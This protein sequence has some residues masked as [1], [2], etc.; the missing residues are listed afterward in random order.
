MSF[1]IAAN[2]ANRII[3]RA[4]QG[5]GGGGCFAMCTII[6]M[7]LVPKQKYTNLVAFISIVYAISLI[8][9][10]IV[11][12]AISKGTTWRWVFLLNV[13][14]A[15]P[16]V[17]IIYF[18]VPRGFPYHNKPKSFKQLT[19]KAT[20]KRVDF[21]GSALLLLATL[22][23][24]AAVEEAGLL[25]GWRSAFVI[26][27]LV[28]SGVLWIL[29]FLWERHITLDHD[30][31][32]AT[33]PVFPWRFTKNRV[34]L[35]MLLYAFEDSLR[36]GDTNASRN[37]SFLGGCW[38][39]TIFQLPLRYQIVHGTSP[40]GAGIRSMPFIAAAPISSAVSAAMSKKGVPP[41]YLVIG[42][43]LLEVIGFSL[44]ATM[45]PTTAITARQYGFEILAG[46]GCG[47]NISLL[48]LLVPFSVEPRDTCM[49]LSMWIN[50][51]R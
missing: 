41:L 28:L 29:F 33:E 8:I 48:V 30:I 26:T 17:L 34:W 32:G 5:L 14:L 25:L 23:L 31:P 45:T 6:C 21:L 49:F 38:F 18:C 24:V 46:F 36:L 3:F 47:T 16:A 13:P 2:G 11:G 4:F 9:G 51:L 43:S 7:D 39:C 15:L 12:G 50:E 44:L 22:S 1:K 19:S 40:L 42:T 35:G 10:P 20:M 37:A 27:L